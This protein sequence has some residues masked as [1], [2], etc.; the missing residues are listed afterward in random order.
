MQKISRNYQPKL[1]SL[2]DLARAIERFRVVSTCVALAW[3]LLFLSLCG[4]P[5]GWMK[6]SDTGAFDLQTT[7]TM[8]QWIKARRHPVARIV[9]G[10]VLWTR[11]VAMPVVPLVHR[12]LYTLDRGTR[13]L[14]GTVYRMAWST[15]LFQSR[16]EA[17]APRLMLYGGIP[18]VLGPLKITLGE[19]CRVSGQTTFTGRSAGDGVPELIVGRNVDIGWQT[20]IAVGTRVV[21]GDH[22]RLSGRCFIAG[23]P[24]HPLDA[25]DRALG[26]P[27]TEDQIG[28]VILED[29]VWLATGVT[30]SAGV[31]IG[32]GTIVAAGSVVT[33]DLPEFC[34]AAGAPARPVRML[35]RSAIEER[36]L[37]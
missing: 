7:L 16:L 13:K 35:H 3:S 25:K 24:G 33:R 17:P 4:C 9:H 5:T 36:G 15:P 1:Q 6:N 29:D 18:L 11:H 31:K 34:L 37:S 27:D 28:D 19:D 12:P 20:T 8:R 26:R 23:Y 22:V 10:L 14:F 32:R 30:V 2:P 21:F